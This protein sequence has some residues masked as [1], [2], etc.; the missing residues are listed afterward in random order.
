MDLTTREIAEILSSNVN[1]DETFPIKE[2]ASYYRKKF[3]FP[4]IAVT[5]TN[6]NTTTKEMIAGVLGT[7]YRVMKSS[8][9]F[10][11]HIGVP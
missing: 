7:R 4:V 3:Q 9:N 6:G 5:G 8:G 10:N 11:N 2:L 1:M